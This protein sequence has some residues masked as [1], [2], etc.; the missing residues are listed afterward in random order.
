MYPA[1]VAA[2]SGCSENISEECTLPSASP[3]GLDNDVYQLHIIS[4]NQNNTNQ[5]Q[6]CGNW[7][8]SVEMQELLLSNQ[9]QIMEQLNTISKVQNTIVQKVALFSVQL[10]DAVL[11]FNQTSDRNSQVT[12]LNE[13]KSITSSSAFC[14]KPITNIQ[15]L[16][17]FENELLQESVKQKLKNTYSVICSGGKGIDCAYS[18]A[19]ILFSRDILCECS[20]SGGSRGNYIKIAWKSYKNIVFFLGYCSFLG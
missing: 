2:V 1:N 18:L 15:E 6:R 4:D 8:Q 5:H 17:K 16:N 7:Q 12:E 10:E 13:T 19:D 3:V 14:F 11:Q 9:T 20:W